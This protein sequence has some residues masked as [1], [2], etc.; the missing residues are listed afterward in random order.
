MLPILY[1]T[2][3]E[4]TVP[5]NYGAGVLSDAISC[6]VTEERNGAFELAL[7]YPA[8]GIHA[9]EIEV[10]NFI[11]AKPNFTD[12]P[13]IFRIY[14]V[15]KIMA[16]KFSVSACHIS[17]DLS[18]KLLTNGS[19]GSCV[20]ACALLEASAGNF[21]INTDKT[22]SGAFRASQPASVR[23]WFG[24][25]EGSI[26]DVYGPGEWKYDNYTASF[27]AARGQ[28]RGVTIR[29]GK[30]LTQLSQEINMSNL[31]T[32]VLPYYVD[33]NGAV[34]TGT[35]KPTGLTLDVEREIA[36]DFSS[37]VDPDS[38]TPI[39]TQLDTLATKYIANNN[40]TTLT[41]SITLDFVQLEGIAERVDLCDT[42]N[43]Y[44]E[45]L[46][47]TAQA[48]CVATTWDVLADR[49]TKTTFGDARTNIADTISNN[50]RQLEQT[51]TTSFMA[52]AITRA[53]ELITG[54][55][56][57]YVILNDTDNNGEPDEILIMNTPDINTATKVWRWNA[58]GLG[59]SSTGY[60]GPYGLA[61]TSDGEI[62]ADYI[63]TGTLNAD[64]IK[65]GTIEDA[66]HNSTIDMTNGA[67][68]MKNFKAISS[69]DLIDTSGKVRGSI[70]YN[71]ID[72]S[73]F[74][75]LDGSGKRLAIMQQNANGGA[76]FIENN[77]GT[78][79][80]TM[81]A[82]GNG[83]AV[84]ISKNN[85]TNLGR[86][87]ST[88]YGGNLSIKN[89]SGATVGYMQANSAAGAS[90]GLLDSSETI[91]ILCSGDSGNVRCVSLTQTSSRKVKENI[92][93]IED[94]EKILELEAVRFDYKNKEQGTDRRGFIA[95][96][97]AE[98]LPN[99]VAPEAEGRPAT[100]DYIGMIPYLQAVLKAQAEEI[101]ELKAKIENMEG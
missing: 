66:G 72:G 46:G 47:I 40:L 58:S 1:K 89:N 33:Q 27:K 39:S 28:N 9:E 22:L 96:D 63:T 38:A 94:A 5:T 59:Y 87:D 67:A 74:E 60:E 84:S 82:Q 43:I 85:G 57:G 79:V 49:Y 62:V 53:T 32:A 12:D 29:Y 35:K 2:I 100:L 91:N 13:Q 34:T 97:V 64:L 37:Q 55:L 8:T 18:G 93:P 73:S 25:K 65:A 26:L 48:K 17:Y 83:G 69:L 101:K 20:A 31:A 24:G 90:L 71:S 15:G 42:V 30:N 21:T 7:E 98:I 50:A 78:V 99:L 19:A 10:N 23:S 56:G 16:G 76:F 44:F 41:N 75:V 54:N 95:E 61:M 36:V 4:G 3:T 68:K 88:I 52:Q 14:K 81:Q 77:S 86:I 70:K 45:A 92:A 11:K 51:P 6:T 80:G